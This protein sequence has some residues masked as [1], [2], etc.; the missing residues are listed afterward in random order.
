MR[1]RFIES[2]D[3]PLLDGQRPDPEPGPG[4]VLISVEACG[5]GTTVLNYIRGDSERD[6]AYLPRIPGHEFVG[7]VSALGSGVDEAMLGQRVMSYFYLACGHC[8]QCLAGVEPTCARTGGNVGVHRDGGYAEQAVLPAFN[9]LP[10]PEGLDSVAATVVPDAVATPVHVAHRSGI[11]MGDRVAVIGAGGGV[12]VHMVQIARLAGGRVCGLDVTAE[13]LEFLENELGVLAVDAS[14]LATCRLPAAWQS[15]A[16][17]VIDFI[18][19]RATLDWALGNL[20]SNGRLVLLTTFRDRT[21]E[22]SPRDLVLRQKSVLGSRYASRA[23]LLTAARLLADGRLRPVIGGVRG[24]DDVDELHDALKA[25][26]LLGR[27]ALVW[28][29]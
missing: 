3:G 16:D 21:F 22:V 19:S 18:G 29:S 1:A 4:E 2:W 27:G 20:A 10:V 25:K 26:T 14:D 28:R 12:G 15:E 11:G 7:T 8:P 9:A 13:K 17:V 24:P 6:P 5:V 23:E